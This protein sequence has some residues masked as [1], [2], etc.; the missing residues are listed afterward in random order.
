M[1]AAQSEPDEPEHEHDCRDDPEYVRCE[2]ESP[3]Q[4]REKQYQKY[5][6]H[7]ALPLRL[8]MP[9][10]PAARWFRNTPTP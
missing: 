7:G 4:Q 2:P 1:A 10:R 6:C 8:R 3:E 5:H 9:P